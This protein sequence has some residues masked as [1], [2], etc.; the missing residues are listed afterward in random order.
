MATPTLHKALIHQPTITPMNSKTQLN[1]LPS[2]L[3]GILS[4]ESLVSL[5]KELR[6]YGKC[7]IIL[8]YVFVA[9]KK[10]FLALSSDT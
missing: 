5:D 3:F 2:I 8:G 6:D 10:I 9:S 7:L 1:I 4:T